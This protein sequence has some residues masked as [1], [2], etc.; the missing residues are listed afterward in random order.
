MIQ[1]C[2]A[3]YHLEI[4]APV[5]WVLNTN[6]SLVHTKAK[7]CYFSDSILFIQ[8]KLQEVDWECS[9]LLNQEQV[10]N[11]P[12]NSLLHSSPIPLYSLHQIY[13]PHT[14]IPTAP[15]L[16]LQSHRVANIYNNHLKL[17]WPLT[18]NQNPLSLSFSLSFSLSKYRCYKV[19]STLCLL[20]ARHF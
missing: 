15:M 16:Q 7:H 2:C 1:W 11:P 10:C 17:N 13:M 20:Y 18:L 19:R 5:G 12:M 14:P 4:T 8:Q 6:N 3:H 9:F